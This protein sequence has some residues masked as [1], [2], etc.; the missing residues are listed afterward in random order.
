MAFLVANSKDVFNQTDLKT[1]YHILS[2]SFTVPGVV[3]TGF[4]LL[5]FASNEGVFDGI[6][7]GVMSFINMFKTRNAKKYSS[8]YDYKQKKHAVKTKTGFILISGLIILSFAIVFLI[9]YMNA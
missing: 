8:L 2:D 5:I 6:T 3:I 1:I 4:G 7:Y 9:L